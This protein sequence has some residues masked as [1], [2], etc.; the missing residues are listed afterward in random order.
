MLY[1]AMM[2]LI[3]DICINCVTSSHFQG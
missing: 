1:D 2:T 3:M